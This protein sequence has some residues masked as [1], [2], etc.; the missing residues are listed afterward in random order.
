VQVVIAFEGS[1]ARGRD[2]RL[3]E[4]SGASLRGETD[5]R[6]AEMGEEAFDKTNL[7]SFQH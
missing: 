6:G 5:A 2:H 1:G 4:G 3:E 7:S